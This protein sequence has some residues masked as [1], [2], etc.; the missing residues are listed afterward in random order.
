MYVLSLKQLRL[1]KSDSLTVLNASLLWEEFGP[2]AQ[3]G[4]SDL[5]FLPP[6]PTKKYHFSQHKAPCSAQH[7]PCAD[8]FLTKMSL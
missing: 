1:P 2:L 4:L 8:F 6:A 3:V 5:I 7:T